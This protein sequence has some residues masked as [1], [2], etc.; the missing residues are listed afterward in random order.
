MGDRQLPASSAQRILLVSAVLVAAP[1]L[2]ARGQEPVPAARVLEPTR[3]EAADKAI[4]IEVGGAA[5]FYGDIDGDGLRDLLVGQLKPARLRV[6]RNVGSKERPRF[7][8]F[9]W[10]KAGAAGD[11]AEVL[12]SVESRVPGGAVGFA[13]QLVDFDGDGLQ[14]VLSCCGKLSMVVFYR[15]PGGSFA[16]GKS[17]K[18]AADREPGAAVY[19]GDWDGDGDLDLV[20]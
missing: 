19:A 8:R 18:R 4:D 7:D 14:D 5:P 17:L 1:N 13:P 2:P 16:E 12:A 6:Y 15:Q 11:P 20:V 10:F 3:C 9:E